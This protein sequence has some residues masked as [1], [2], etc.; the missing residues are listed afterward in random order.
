MV[1]IE[2]GA[3]SPSDSEAERAKRDGVVE[4]GWERGRTKD[5]ADEEGEI[6]NYVSKR[7]N[8]LL[9][10]ATTCIERG[11]SPMGSISLVVPSRRP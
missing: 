2:G 7:V 11:R 6:C 3:S 1:L 9:C 5:G 4:G 10:N 8:G